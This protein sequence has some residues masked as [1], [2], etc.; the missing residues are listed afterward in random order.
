[1]KQEH[2]LQI[3]GAGGHG[4]VVLDIAKLTKRF[5]LIRCYDDF[6]T[7]ENVCGT[8]E[9][10]LADA[11]CP[12]NFIIAL[13]DNYTR[14]KKFEFLLAQGKYPIDV[15]RHPSAIIADTA[16]IGE[17]SVIM[18]GVVINP[19]A[20][21]G[22]NVIVNT[23]AIIEHDCVVGDHAHIA[24]GAVLCGAAQV[25]TYSWIGAGTVVIEKS[26]VAKGCIVGAGS[27]VIKDIPSNNMA[28]GVPAKVIKPLSHKASS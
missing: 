10:L 1:M 9:T 12:S 26:K 8:L 4:K 23:G 25:G 3:L 17:G 20:K 2:Q 11:E 7:S 21:I 24:P 14:A 18:A 6:A 15:V 28:V 27:V 19:Y 13:G 5:A 22:R 16:S